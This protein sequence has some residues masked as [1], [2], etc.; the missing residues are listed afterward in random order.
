MTGAL[1]PTIRNGRLDTVTRQGTLISTLVAM[2][3]RCSGSAQCCAEGDQTE[4]CTDH[5]FEEAC[6]LTDCNAGYGDRKS[7]QQPV[8]SCSRC[9][10]EDNR[11]DEHQHFLRNEFTPLKGAR[12]LS[13]TSVGGRL[14]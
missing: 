2:L 13:A 10:Q 6:C 4:S 1:D 14:N 9:D 3:G 8:K 11:Y 12:Y 5:E 7:D